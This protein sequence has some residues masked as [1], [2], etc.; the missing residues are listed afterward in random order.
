MSVRGASAVHRGGTLR[1]D[2]S[3]DLI[4]SLDPAVSDSPQGWALL[5]STGDGLVGVKRVSGLDGGTI[6]ADLA[7]SVPTPTDGGLIYTFQLRPGLRYS[8]GT[9]VRAGDVRRGLERVFRVG[10]N[11]GFYDGIVGADKCSKASC[12]LSRGVVTDDKTGTVTMHLRAADPE[13]LY[14]LTVPAGW[15]VPPST[16]F[17][18]AGPLGVPGTGPYVIVS[19]GPKRIVLARNPYFH[20][21]SAAAQPD[22]YPDRIVSNLAGTP[23]RQL[24]EVEQGRAD[25]DPLTELR[26]RDELATRYSAQVHIFPT[27]GVYGLFLNTRV[28]PFDNL[29]A[30]Q[31]VDYAID[32]REVAAGF[33]TEGAVVTCQI[34]PPGSPGYQPQCLYTKRPGT[35]WSAP[36]LV[37]ARKLVATSGTRDDKVVVWT[38]GHPTGIAIGTVAVKTLDELGY[39]ASLKSIPSVGA[40]FS[41]IYNPRNRA[42]IGFVGWAADYPAASEF[43]S[44]FTCHAARTGNESASQ[45]CNHGLDVA[46]GGALTAQSDD[47][48]GASTTWAKIDRM[49]GATHR[50]FRS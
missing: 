10:G 43:L 44:L 11:S 26:W 14:K 38:I 5:A 23:G 40:Y 29:K 33:G 3:A 1:V 41:A 37:R 49:V 25:Y 50:G 17:K 30:R 7:T 18:P 6:V 47:S 39:R 13:F 9:P 42:Q 31:A 36:D 35:V 15:P 28:A 27:P 22:G 2:V 20:Q 16:P 46:I 24:T 45:L 32:R 21:W 8:N 34:L 48:A 12:D 4:D 19:H